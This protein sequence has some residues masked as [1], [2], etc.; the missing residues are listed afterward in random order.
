MDRDRIFSP[1]NI[2]LWMVATKSI[3]VFFWVKFGRHIAIERIMGRRLIG[4]HVRNDSVAEKL[5]YDLG[6][7]ANQP[8]G[9]RQFLSLRS[10]DKVQSLFQIARHSVEIARLEA[11]L[12]A[13]GI[14]FDSKKSCPIHGGGERLSASHATQ[15]G[16]DDKSAGK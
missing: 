10:Q 9:Q 12:D 4:E 7:V 3:E 8:D 16:R 13:R 1:P 6:G 2:F 11:A 5:R 14:D 15:S